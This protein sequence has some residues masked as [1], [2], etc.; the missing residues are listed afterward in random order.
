MRAWNFGVLFAPFAAL[1]IF[2]GIA[3][4]IKWLIAN[5]MP[6]CWLKRQLLAERLKSKCSESNRRI[7]EQSRLKA[8]R[9][10]RSILRD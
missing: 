2:G 3:L 7:L 6:E 10:S 9:D 5:Y 1:I 4:P 8:I